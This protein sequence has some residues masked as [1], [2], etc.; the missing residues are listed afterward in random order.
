[1]YDDYM[2]LSERNTNT[3]NTEIRPN[4]EIY[5]NGYGP[6]T[7]K[8]CSKIH[9]I[10]NMAHTHPYHISDKAVTHQTSVPF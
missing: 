10:P 6:Y 7:T 9:T 1:M 5:P 4:F 2:V 8:I 3:S